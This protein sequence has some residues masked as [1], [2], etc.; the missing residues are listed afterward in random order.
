MGMINKLSINASTAC[1]PG[2][3]HTEAM[4][5]ILSGTSE[6]VIGNLGVRHI[7]LCPQNFGAMT[8]EIASM[9]AGSNSAIRFRLHAGVRID[10]CKTVHDAGFKFDATV[11]R[12]FEGLCEVGH[13]LGYMPYT[14]HAGR[15]SECSLEGMRDNIMRVEDIMGRVVGVEGMYPDNGKY[16][17]QDWDE[18][19]W[20]HQSELAF[21]LDMS[22]LNIISNKTGSVD[23][24][25]VS[26][27]ISNPRCIEIHISGNDG[28]SDRHEILSEIPWW[29][30]LLENGIRHNPGA[31]IFSEGNQRMSEGGLPAFIP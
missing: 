27:M 16:L 25:L 2:L 4:R 19:K 18:Y 13:A 21:A 29:A 22:H 31:I 11:N 28:H 30:A 6:P 3:S 8:P 9:I 14:M 20:L 26:E 12:Y 23:H 17:I 10:G 24:G 7:Q 5:R 1:W 15:R